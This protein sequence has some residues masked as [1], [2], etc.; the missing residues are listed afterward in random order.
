[1]RLEAVVAEYL[2]DFVPADDAEFILM[3]QTQRVFFLPEE[4]FGQLYRV[5]EL[6]VAEDDDAFD[7]DAKG[8]VQWIGH[9]L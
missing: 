5:F 4:A 9:V 1:M 8:E 3:C 2:N 7:L 6:V